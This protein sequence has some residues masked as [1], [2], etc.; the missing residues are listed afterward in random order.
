MLSPIS[1]TARVI[2]SFV[3]VSLC[4]LWSVSVTQ[5][6]WLL[7]LGLV[8]PVGLLCSHTAWRC[9]VMLKDL[10][11]AL[12]S[13]PGSPEYENTVDG[14]RQ[15]ALAINNWASRHTASA[16]AMLALLLVYFTHSGFVLIVGLIAVPVAT[17]WPALAKRFRA[18]RD[19]QA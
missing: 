15:A 13:S 7:A 11:L 5:E 18:W 6:Y 10:L 2:F 1:L 17:S 8:V 4:L 9:I 16:I 3:W 14:V 19:A 12:G